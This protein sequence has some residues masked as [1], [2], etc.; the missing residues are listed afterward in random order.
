M[1]L[2]LE[3]MFYI[4]VILTNNILLKSNLTTQILKNL[5]TNYD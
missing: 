3:L 5:Y 1:R 4:I 2:S